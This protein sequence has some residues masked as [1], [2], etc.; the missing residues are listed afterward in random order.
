MAPNPKDTDYDRRRQTIV[1]IGFVI[2][3]WCN[4]LKSPNNQN[5]QHRETGKRGPARTQRPP[6]DVCRSLHCYR[7]T[8]A[9]DLSS[10]RIPSSTSAFEIF[11]G[12][13]M[14][15]TFPYIPPLPTS[16]PFARV[17]SRI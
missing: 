17:R 1:Q 15:I 10:S 14:R 13:A 12:G 2:R 8:S 6:L 3:E 5:L 4:S 11:I 16:K 9:N 7:R